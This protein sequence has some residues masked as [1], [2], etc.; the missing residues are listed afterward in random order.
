MAQQSLSVEQKQLVSIYTLFESNA[1]E[2]C[3]F[4][5]G[6]STRP[7]TRYLEHCDSVRFEKEDAFLSRGR[8]LILYCEV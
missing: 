7:E 1:E 4:Y 3:I 6:Y 8:T 2:K 5:I